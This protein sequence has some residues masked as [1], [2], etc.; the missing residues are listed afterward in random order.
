MGTKR[1]G[2][3]R[4]AAAMLALFLVL[5]MAM[6]TI[7]M[8]E[9]QYYRRTGDYDYGYQ[10][11]ALI[12]I[13]QLDGNNFTG[14]SFFAYC[15][16]KYT[17]LNDGKLILEPLDINSKDA[18]IRSIFM[19]SYPNVSLDELKNAVNATLQPGKKISFLSKKEAI[20]GA[21]F[22][23]WYYSNGHNGKPTNS[24]AK[25][26]YNYLK[27]LDGIPA[28]SIG[29]AHASITK[30]SE[31][32]D[33]DGNAVFKLS[34]PTSAGKNTNGSD[35]SLSYDFDKDLVA[36]YNANIEDSEHGDDTIVT[37]TIPAINFIDT[38]SFKM[39]ISGTQSIMDVYQFSPVSDKNQTLVGYTNKKNDVY[40]EEE[41]SLE[42][43]EPTTTTTAEPTTTTTA[44]PTTTTTAEPT[45]TTTA[46]PTTTTTAEPTTTTTAEPTTTTT[47]EPTTTTT[48]EPTT[49][50]TAEPTT[51]TTAEPTTTTTAEPTTTTTAEPTTTT[52]A[53]PTT[54]TTAEP[55]TTTT[56]EPTTT[57]TAEPT[58][59]TTAEPTTTTTA[60]PTTTT[61][62]EPTTTTTAE[63]TTTTTAEPTTTT[64]AEPTTTTTAEPT[65]TTTAEPTT[66]TAEPT[67]TTAEPT[68]T[69]AEPTTTTTAEP[70]TTTTAEP[71]TTT[72]EPTTGEPTTG[73][74]TTGE[75]PTTQ[76]T[77]STP[78][79]PEGTTRRFTPAQSTEA[80]TVIIEDETIPEGAATE[81]FNVDALKVSVPTTQATTQATTSDEI[82]LDEEIPLGDALPQ[83]GQLPAELYYGIGGL[84]TAAGV[85]LR[86]KK[87]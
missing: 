25:K 22:A 75:E 76:S 57:T 11:T 28:S 7:S 87:Q 64:T 86:K 81:P 84:V 66:T 46:E 74:P 37:V 63:P 83:T 3:R 62:A 1:S 70:T 31:E 8:A 47:A 40:D 13:R 26:V 4:H 51:T 54:T 5:V 50:T 42:K 78:F 20:T 65:T 17:T 9:T 41:C 68:T 73:E 33:G 19:N 16:D 38:I 35:V 58:T 15:I 18:K 85:F 69:T 82:I 56:A 72:A 39:S 29:Q 23:L 10:D 36:L 2:I 49:T 27:D 45:T 32:I 79:V 77:T 67:T 21:Q 14:S 30:I 24:D 44:E 60:E 55:T 34:F 6:P 53:E 52:T 59:T 80:E 48:A 43:P 12:Y 71:T 61:T